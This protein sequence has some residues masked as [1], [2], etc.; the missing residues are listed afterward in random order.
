MLVIVG[1]IVGF[2]TLSLGN[3]N[4]DVLE[5]EARRLAALMPLALQEAMLSARELGFVLDEGQYTFLLLG[6]EGWRPVDDGVLRARTLAPQVEAVLAGDE[7]GP[8][9]PEQEAPQPQIL[10]LSSG[11]VTPFELTLRNPNVG[12][13][14][15]L[16]GTITGEIRM[17][18]HDTGLR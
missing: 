12:G 3:R 2:A 8:A 4:R 17:T 9:E 6:P 13:Y 18:Q 15:R 14:F 1:V 10:F 5:R 16:T 11:Q 7:P